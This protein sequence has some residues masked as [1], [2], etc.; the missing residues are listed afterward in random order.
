MPKMK[1]KRSAAKRFKVSAKG[2][3]LRNKANHSHILTKKT[4]KR[5][6]QLK[7]G[8]QVSRSDRKRMRTFILE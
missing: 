5:K 1:S 3:I 8:A 4:R 6:R 7:A 2:K